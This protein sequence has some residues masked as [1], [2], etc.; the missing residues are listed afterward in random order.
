MNF[1]NEAVRYFKM[2]GIG[3]AVDILIVAYVIY[4]LIT[5]SRR[6]N[7][8]QVFKGIAVL[9]IVAWVSKFL[10]LNL[11][12]FLLTK[13]LEIGLLALVVLFQPELR[14]AFEKMGS[15]GFSQFYSDRGTSPTEL[16]NAIIQTVEAC[17]S[18]SWSRTGALIVFEREILL[19][20]I[21]KTG[22]AIDA[23]V[24]AELLKNV[25]FPNSPLHDGALI[26]QRG[27]IAAAGC[28]LPLS[29]NINISKALGMR[30]RAGVGMS[31]N[32]DAV[33]VVVSEETG[34]VSVA[35]GGML[36]RHLAPETLEKLLRNELM[37]KTEEVKKENVI[38]NF[39]FKKKDTENND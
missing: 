38:F 22:T 34:S 5:F 30:H 4:K 17:K 19:T 26:V 3:D 29:G 39:F 35:I 33:V 14:K 31:E 8:G 9:L 27:R 11:L 24:N 2:F 10:R 1:L 20:N 37:P 13:T 15:K 28:M 36:K 21:I 18:L 23:K 16:E 32:S 12:S 6:T 7:A 25:F